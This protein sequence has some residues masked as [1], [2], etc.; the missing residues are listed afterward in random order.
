MSHCVDETYEVY[1]ERTRCARKERRCS[2]CRETIRC[3]DRYVA[4]FIVF[5]GEPERLSRCARCQV[6]HKH[7]RGK[8]PGEMWPDEKLACGEGYEEHWGEEPPPE[9]AELAFV[10][11]DEMQAK[12]ALE[13]TIE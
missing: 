3:G 5:Q 7:L 12:L 13:R 10:T 4:I 6:V 11:A 1:S 8:D 9:I 2:A